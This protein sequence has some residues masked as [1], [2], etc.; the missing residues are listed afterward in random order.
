MRST[1]KQR[2]LSVCLRLG[3]GACLLAAVAAAG[4]AGPTTPSP[5]GPVIT[6]S[7][8]VPAD[9]PGGAAKASLTQAAAFAWQE[10]I[11]LNWPAVAQ[12]GGR[13][14]RGT[15]D[16]QLRF[17]AAGGAG[18]LVW[19]TYRSKVEI[20][21]GA[22]YPPGYNPAVAQ[23]GKYFGFD[24]LPVYNYFQ[25]VP[26]CPGETS[27]PTP[28]INLDEV[29]QITLDDMSAGVV[30]GS[31]PV[32]SAPQLIR[33]LAKGN[34]AQYD[35]IAAQ[36]YWNFGGNFYAAVQTFLNSVQRNRVPPPQNV[37]TFPNGTIEVKAAWRMLTAGDDASRFHTA[38][39]RY[40]ENLPSTDGGLTPT[41]C[42]RQG[43]WG[44]IAL[45]IIQKTPSAP[46]FIFASF[47]QA[48]NILLPDG[49]PVEDADGKVIHPPPAG[50]PPTTP[51]PTYQD[52]YDKKTKQQD[53]A[54]SIG[55]QSFCTDTGQR[56]YYANLAPGLPKAQGAADGVICINQRY[57]PIPPAIIKANRA[58]HAAIAKY[59]GGTGSPWQYYKLVNVQAS[60]FDAAAID[61]RSPDSTHNPSTYY[62]ANI[63]VE[64][65]STLQ[66]FNGVLL[67]TGH[68]AGVNTSFNAAGGAAHNVY[69]PS[70]GGYQAYNMGG[71]MGCHGNAQAAGTDFSF[72]LN[73]GPV[74]F[75]EAPAATPATKHDP[76]KL[77]KYFSAPSH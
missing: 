69:V 34:R 62:M 47:G 29:T 7:P 31:S 35:Y 75:P 65:D 57:N 17:G 46:S 55:D 39:V 18:P 19:E 61:T 4:P 53:P 40:Y 16:A 24:A 27:A 60:P 25:P 32:N 30:A 33:F 22:G 37:V 21:P 20:F 12:D 44:L 15:A 8:V 49:T 58:A 67:A 52:G 76:A 71:C 41:P 36:Q 45:H 43:T 13:G 1:R 23:K 28:W 26:A 2:P 77:L 14:Q 48:D 66:R 9:I 74:F 38:T 10:F 42:Y 59:Q 6:I 68:D 73:E 63:V 70:G 3:A 64:T 50:T 5:A 72:I 54:V 11:A 51:Y 56:L